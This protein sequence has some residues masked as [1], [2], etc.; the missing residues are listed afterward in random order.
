MKV[1]TVKAKATTLIRAFTISAILAVLAPAFSSA[2][3]TSPISDSSAGTWTTAP[4]WSRINDFP[5]TGTFITESTG[6]G[7]AILNLASVPD[8]APNNQCAVELYA[9]VQAGQKGPESLSV[10]IYVGDISV[11]GGAV[12]ITLTRGGFTLYN[13]GPFTVTTGSWDTLQVALTSSHGGAKDGESIEVGSVRIICDDPPAANSPPTF[14]GTPPASATEDIEY[15]YTA[16]ATD[17]DS[18]P[19]TWNVLGDDTCG[20]V[21]TGNAYTFTEPG[22]V[23]SRASCYLSI[24]VCDNAPACTPQNATITIIA[25]NDPPIITSS[26]P[27]T[28]TAGELY[29]YSAAA[30]DDDGPGTTWSV[31]GTDT[32]GGSFAGNVYSF[33][34]A[35]EGSCDVAIQVCDG[36]SPD[37]CA[38][39]GPVTVTISAAGNAAPTITTTAPATATEDTLYSYDANLSDP[40]GPGATWSVPGTDTCGGSINASTGVY[41]FTPAGPTPPASCTLAI[42][43][44]DGGVPDLCDSE[45]ATITITAV[46]DPP[47]ITSSAPTTAVVAVTYNYTPNVSDPD[48]TGANWTVPG[49]DTCGGTFAGGTYSF[50]PAAAGNCDLAIRVCDD[51]G[52]CDTEGPTTITITDTAVLI[53][54]NYDVNGGVSLDCN[55]C[56]AFHGGSMV[57]TENEVYT[58]CTQCHNS[59]TFPDPGDER[60]WDVANHTVATETAPATIINVDCGQCH[61][62]HKNTLLSDASELEAGGG[63]ARN[64]AYI[65]VNMAKYISGALTNTVFQEDPNH[66]GEYEGSGVGTPLNGVCQSCHRDNKYHNNI[67]TGTDHKLSSG[68]PPNTT[69]CKACHKH[70]TGNEATNATGGSFAA[71][72]GHSDTDFGWDSN[73]DDCH[74]ATPGSPTEAIV[75]VIHGDNCD[76]CHTNP[77]GTT[78]ASSEGPGPV[79]NGVDGDASLANGDAG[80]WAATCT[81][82]HNVADPDVNAASMGGIHH[83]NATDGVVTEAQCTTKCHTVTGH[84]GS[85]NTT[86]TATTNCSGCHADTAGATGAAVLN[87][88]DD[89]IHDQCTSC[90]VIASTPGADGQLIDPATSTLVSVMPAGGGNCNGCHGDWFPN[91]LIGDHKTDAL[92]DSLLGA[93]SCTTTCHDGSSAA[94]IITNT[95]YDTC[96]NCHTNTTTN[97]SLK[98][99]TNGTALN[100]TID[101]QSTC[102][103]CHGAPYD[104]D[105]QFQTAHDEGDHQTTAL[106]DV[107]TATAGCTVNCHDASNLAKITGSL[108][109]GCARCHTN[110]STNGTLVNAANGNA[111]NHVFNTPSDCAKC[112]TDYASQFETAHDAE[113]HVELIGST[114]CSS[115]HTGNILTDVRTHG[116]GTNAACTLCHENTTTDGRLLDGTKAGSTRDTYAA[117]DATVAAGADF[118][119]ECIE[120]HSTYSGSF[121]AH[122]R[123]TDHDKLDSTASC[124]TNCHTGSVYAT[125]GP[126]DN[127][128]AWCHADALGS[129]GTLLNGTENGLPYPGGTTAVGTAAGHDITVVSTCA[130]C[131]SITGNDYSQNFATAH[132]V[133]DHTGVAALA[134]C[135]TNC[136]DGSSAAN[137]ITNTHKDNCVNCHSNTT[138]D[139]RL[140]DGSVNSGSYGAPTGT[141]ENRGDATG[142]A[143][144]CASCHLTYSTNFGNGHMHEDHTLLTNTGSAEC[145]TCHYGFIIVGIHTHNNNCE[146]CHND[147]ATDGTLIGSAASHTVGS[148]S[149]CIDCHKAVDDDFAGGHTTETHVEVT[150]PPDSTIQSNDCDDCHTGDIITAPINHNNDCELCHI[151]TITI[152]ATDGRFTGSATNHTIFSIS[153]CMVCHSNDYFTNAASKH[154]EGSTDSGAT[155]TVAVDGDTSGGSLC[156]SC[157]SADTGAAGDDWALILARH[158]KSTTTADACQVCHDSTRTANTVGSVGVQT[159]ILNNAGR[160][161]IVSCLDCHTDKSAGHGGHNNPD[162]MIQNSTNCT[163]GSCHGGGTA[164]PYVIHKVYDATENPGGTDN[165][166]VCHTSSTGGGAL[167]EPWETNNTNGGTCENCHWTIANTATGHHGFDRTVGTARTGRAKNGECARCHWPDVGNGPVDPSTLALGN[168]GTNGL[169]CNWCHLYWNTPTD[170]GGPGNGY[171]VASGKVQ[172]HRVSWDPVINPNQAATVVPI[173][174]HAISENTTTPIS[175]YAACLNCHGASF[176]SKGGGFKVVPFHGFGPTYNGDSE[177]TGPDAANFINIYSGPTKTTANSGAH[178]YGRHPGWMALGGAIPD[179][180]NLNKADGKT[181]YKTNSGFGGTKLY[182]ADNGVH[183]SADCSYQTTF[184]VPWDD[185]APAAGATPGSVTKDLGTWYGANNI[186]TAMPVVPLSLP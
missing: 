3:T 179:L 78:D 28:A 10:D 168:L 104:Y 65:R 40:D 162:S 153:D 110:M 18:D 160:T 48:G 86:V 142:G 47:A 186:P 54:H 128:C 1:S 67:D 51:G 53:G 97:G 76:L 141:D 167:W 2:A 114:K 63:I 165:C 94:N 6:A 29:S 145:T 62:V 52:L 98:S 75:S 138:T 73:C 122:Q 184:N 163:T 64:L 25:V 82:C 83:D 182:T 46:N 41:T 8:P 147:R 107:L 119:W 7:T 170:E 80:T 84:E 105:S 171:D 14:D 123:L 103:D 164:H 16:A 72:G 109:T 70:G 183:D 74:S 55:T 26:A 12:P 135:T 106:A 116:D 50:I 173:A 4:L 35:A 130:D 180:V 89:K 158:D 115:C 56:H 108:H 177:T 137:I 152:N 150:A 77:T 129:D 30:A 113:T 71:T 13:S 11:T 85:H 90:H 149:A 87:A 88:S 121:G 20:G 169:A 136:H 102:V 38:T 117:G 118:Q 57:P 32:C 148:E 93:V 59:T 157:H 45:T 99:G 127:A 17:P 60:L 31:L 154:S 19:L 134:S 126:H 146:S 81:T 66:F 61:E 175:D 24:E 79:A 124:T 140:V 185:Y 161:G 5:D 176:A 125:G 112:H 21:F 131:H 15:S 91:H 166:S 23:P 155:H 151:D 69:D 43:V 181:H 120:C 27:T 36:G 68:G 159:I 95:H 58:A 143:G 100:H 33:T 44:C 22:P 42:Q 39:E 172:I 96:T 9:N 174:S 178:T 101:S 34:P 144:D 139:G 49:T 111:Q 156:S 132:D 37:L 133:V 92:A